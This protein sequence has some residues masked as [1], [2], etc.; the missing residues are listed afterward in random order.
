M[1]AQHVSSDSVVLAVLRP[2][3][4]A[5]T[6]CKSYAVCPQDIHTS[7][8]VPPLFTTSGGVARLRDCMKDAVL[9][10]F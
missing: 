8:E 7:I 4:L 3:T 1:S 10:G 9:F 6:S 2:V 5:L